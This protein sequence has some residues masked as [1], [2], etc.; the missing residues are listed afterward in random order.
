MPSPAV[1]TTFA[2]PDPNASPLNLQQLITLLNALVS[3]AIQ[4]TYIPY[5]ISH[6]TPGADDHDK[7]WIQLDS[8]GRPI[9]TKI[10]YVGPGGGNWRRVYNGMLNEVRGYSGNPGDDFDANGRGLVGQTYD[11]WHLCNGQDG[12]PDLSDH[13]LIGAHMS[14]LA[15]GYTGGEWKTNVE[16]S[17]KHS[18]GNA[19]ITLDAA[20]TYR[21][22]IDVRVY[23]RSAPGD[24]S[25]PAGNLAGITAPSQPYDL[26]ND[27]GNATPTPIDI[28]N[29]Y[30]AL[31]WIIF[32][33]YT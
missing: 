25:D 1:L 31:G 21:P 10:W 12:T 28:V 5:V 6:D 30:I 2:N 27:A 8:G 26:Y 29:P 9:A 4:G 22:A 24:T 16:G 13:F 19:T 18:G 3:S 23:K 17:S 15:I 33:G 32:I 20:N 7:A 11:G 14:D